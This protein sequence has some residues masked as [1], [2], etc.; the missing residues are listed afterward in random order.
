MVYVVQKDAAAL[1]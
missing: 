1:N